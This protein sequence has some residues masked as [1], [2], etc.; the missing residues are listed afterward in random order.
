VEPWNAWTTG[1]ALKERGNGCGSSPAL[2]QSAM[3]LNWM[4]AR[5][6][7]AFALGWIP[8]ALQADAFIFHRTHFTDEPEWGQEWPHY[9]PLILR[10]ASA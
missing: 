3:T 1:R 2:F 7:R 5:F 8:S 9:F 10:K 6:P 4:A